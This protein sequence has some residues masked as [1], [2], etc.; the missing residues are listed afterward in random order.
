MQSGIA[1]KKIRALNNKLTI[2]IIIAIRII[3][4]ILIQNS[5]NSCSS[6]VKL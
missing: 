6:I 4:F 1:N 3:I 2:I 5:K